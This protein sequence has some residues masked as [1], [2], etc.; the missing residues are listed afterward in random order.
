MGGGGFET[1]TTSTRGEVLNYVSSL[2]LPGGS[3]SIIQFNIDFFFLKK[4]HHCF[5][6]RVSLAIKVL[7]V[8]I[9]IFTYI[10]DLV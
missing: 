5:P 1:L 7:L 8:K 2:K 6:Q 3:C 9:Y 10:K 4:G